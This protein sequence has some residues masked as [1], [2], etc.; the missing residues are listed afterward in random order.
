MKYITALSL[1]FFVFIGSAQVRSPAEFLGYELGEKFTRHG[2]VVRYFESVADASNQVV[3]QEYGRTYE[4]RLLL[5]AYIASDENM[6]QLETIREDNL[7][8]TGL[9]DGSPSTDVTIV[10]LS[11]NVHGNES[12]STEASMATIYELL[13]TAKAKKWLENTVVIID[14]CIN[15]DGRDRYVNFYNQYGNLSFNP[16]PQSME[17]RE[18]WPGGRANHYLFDLNRDWAWQTQ[19][20]SQERIKEYNKWMPHVHVDFHEQSHNSPYYFAP[21]AQPYH[22]LVTQWQRDFQETIGRNHAKYF[23][24]NNW[25][26][27]TR[28]YFDL[29]YPSYGDTYPLYNG[30]IGMTYEQG[31]GG[32]AG[33]GIIKQEGDTLTL[34]DRLTHHKTTGLSTVEITS[35]NS[36]K[37]LSEF[38]KFFSSP[39]KGKYKSFILKSDNEDKMIHLKAWLDSNGIEYGK[40][41]SQKG[42]RGYHY[43][44]GKERSFNIEQNDLVVTTDQPR[45]VMAKILFEPNTKLV[46]SLT[47]DITAWAVPYFYG[48]ETYA[49]S[50]TISTST[51]ES[52]TFAPVSH[53]GKDVYAYLY[54]WNS[55][56]DAQFLAEV[57]KA[58]IKVRYTTRVIR[59]DDKGFDRGT[60][61]VSKRDNSSV[62]NFEKMMTD[63]ANDHGRTGHPLYTGFMDGGPDIGSND[64]RYINPPK[65]ALLG[66][67]G[68]SSLNVGATW[69]F[70]EQQLKYPMNMLSSDEVGQ[71]EL[72]SYNVII[73][74]EGRYSN[75]DDGDMEKISDWVSDGGKLVLFQSAIRK[76]ADTDY[77]SISKYNSDDEKSEIEEKEKLRAEDSKLERY[78]ESQRN[79]AKYIIPGAIF[80]VSLDNSHPMAYGYGESYYSLKTTSA[81]YGYLANQNVGVIQS[82]NDHRSGFVGQYVKESIPKSMVF[83]VENRGKGQIVYFADN[84]LFRNFWY[85]G[86][87]MVA[88]ALFFVGQ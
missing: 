72:A 20:E 2:D 46:D 8:R 30:A 10:W 67:E 27:F 40:G 11:Y 65:I 48:M 68:T 58:E 51:H 14:P 23:D 59:L 79:S 73:M 64:I 7:R 81:R 12:N 38:G 69:H 5:L 71:M 62:E 61:I 22:E 84:V 31:G 85:D 54:K 80:K 78:E 75:F 63:M 53:D 17:H 24:K 39:V 52:S 82:S 15:P 76:F 33:L 6:A 32:R 36:T 9:M 70:M 44:S 66:G 13:T 28:Q 83:G 4:N 21:A 57:L 50:A 45:G 77:A 41:I 3:L 18:P 1:L 88:N 34:L 29:L 19:I 56:K 74:Q 35:Q 37:V 43:G 25:F 42:L 47:Y 26:Y 16:D 60:L 86:K 55:L 87:L 49:T